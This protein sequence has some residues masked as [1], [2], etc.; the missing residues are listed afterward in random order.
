LELNS[1]ARELAESLR[2]YDLVKDDDRTALSIRRENN[3][4]EQLAVDLILSKDVYSPS[5]F[6]QPREIGN[7]LE[8]MTEALS[9]AEHDNNKPPEME[10]G[11]LTPMIKGEE[12]KKK[13]D[14]DQEQEHEGEDMVEESSSEKVS[15]PLGV[16]LLLK[17]WEVGTKAKDYIF[18][19]PY[20]TTGDSGL[21]HTLH[22]AIQ[23]LRQANIIPSLSQTSQRPPTVMSSQTMT[24]GW[25]SASQQ[26]PAM[27]QQP[28]PVVRPTG[29]FGSQPFQPFGPG[30]SQP[31]A[32]QTNFSQSTE[33]YMASTQVLPGPN[34]GR[35]FLSKK[36]P[37]KKRLGGF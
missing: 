31:Q 15:L 26:P 30:L 18:Q 27:V 29:M 4:R 28:Y 35:P 6:R 25:D 32:S 8:T 34:G 2:S 9:L 20:N 22:P 17:D 3:A 23:R 14:H 24:S 33:H 10:F 7:E 16:R 11:Y 36:K 12:E 37:P 1:N 13:D 19:D 5:A 21:R